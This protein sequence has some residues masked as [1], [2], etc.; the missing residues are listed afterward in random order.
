MRTSDIWFVR[1]AS[2]GGIL[3]EKRHSMIFSREKSFHRSTERANTSTNVDVYDLTENYY[4]QATKRNHNITLTRYCHSSIFVCFIIDCCK[5]FFDFDSIFRPLL[6]L[7]PRYG[8]SC[9]LKILF[10]LRVYIYKKEYL[11]QR[12]LRKFKS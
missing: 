1:G 9:V 10:K 3:H 8:N 5:N 6:V 4:F 7:D 12:K 11:K 2:S